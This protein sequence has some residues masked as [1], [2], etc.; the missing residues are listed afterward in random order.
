MPL[1]LLLP[2]RKKKYNT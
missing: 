1:A 2:D